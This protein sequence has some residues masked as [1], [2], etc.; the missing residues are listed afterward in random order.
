MLDLEDMLDHFIIFPTPKQFL[1]QPRDSCEILRATSSPLLRLHAYGAL[2][3]LLSNIAQCNDLPKLSL[4][5]DGSMKLN[6][7]F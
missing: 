6:V 4:D 5:T 1:D 7:D 3:G 2:S